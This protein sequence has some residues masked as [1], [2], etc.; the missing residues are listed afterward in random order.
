MNYINKP[1]TSVNKLTPDL[2]DWKIL[3]TVESRTPLTQTA[4]S[5][6]VFATLCDRY[7]NKISLKLWNEAAIAFDDQLVQGEGEYLIDGCS[8]LIGKA[9]GPNSKGNTLQISVNDERKL[10]IRKVGE[11][12]KPTPEK[13]SKKPSPTDKTSNKPSPTKNSEGF[14]I[15]CPNRCKDEIVV[16]MDRGRSH[17]RCFSCRVD[18]ANANKSPE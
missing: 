17:Y 5:I 7:N 13:S 8:G 6:Y 9:S 1:I 12:K 11:S 15:P 18:F 2:D 4:K 3:V 16:L 10:S 14:S